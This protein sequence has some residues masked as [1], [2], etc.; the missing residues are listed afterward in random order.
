M[1]DDDKGE[2]SSFKWGGLIKGILAGAAVLVGIELVSDGLISGLFSGVGSGGGEA[3]GSFLKDSLS[4]IG[5]IIPKIAGVAL[6]A[7]GL[8][9]L[10]SD[11]SQAENTERHSQQYA[12]AKE[13]FA[14]REDMRKMQAVMMAR[15]KASGAA[16]GAGA[17]IQPAR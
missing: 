4:G 9:Y 6:G 3:I 8:S 10:F 1:S 15:M 7:V 13:S 12:E 14:V 17:E 2:K 11:K 5:D 16:V